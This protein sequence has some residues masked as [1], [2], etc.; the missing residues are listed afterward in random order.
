MIAL[1]FLYMF[2]YIFS[3]FVLFLIVYCIVREMKNIVYVISKIYV[4]HTSIYSIHNITK[5][6]DAAHPLKYQRTAK[7][8]F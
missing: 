8:E 7:P 2:I 4:F 5:D 6:Q 1:F 3:S